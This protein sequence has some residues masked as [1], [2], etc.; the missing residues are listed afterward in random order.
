MAVSR[1]RYGSGSAPDTVKSTI[2]VIIVDI[3]S[4][5]SG[6][7][8]GND[9]IEFNNRW[10]TIRRNGPSSSTHPIRVKAATTACFVIHASDITIAIRYSVRDARTCDTM[11]LCRTL[12]Y[13]LVGPAI[14]RRSTFWKH[15][16]TLRAGTSD[17]SRDDS[18]KDIKP[19]ITM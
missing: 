5:C 8:S 19:T 15:N 4:A 13:V 2:L 9:R 10:T 1:Y 18:M 11:I 6:V 3:M 17:D 14:V 7:C 12:Y 16:T